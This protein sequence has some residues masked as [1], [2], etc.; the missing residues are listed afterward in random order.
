MAIAGIWREGADASP[1]AFA[2][3]TIAP[4]PDVEPYH[5]RQVVVL[6][7]ADW[8]HWIYLTK[9]ETEMLRPLPEKSLDVETVREASDLSCFIG[10]LSMRYRSVK[11][12]CF[13]ASISYAAAGSLQCGHWLSGSDQQDSSAASWRPRRMSSI[14]GAA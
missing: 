2:M 12:N 14:T 3:L 11:A 5:D 10:L 13:W 9:S 8:A 6:R 1:P 7:P 4:R